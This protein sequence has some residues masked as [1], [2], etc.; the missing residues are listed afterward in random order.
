MHSVY[1][2]FYNQ[3]TYF[4]FHFIAPVT[5][6]DKLVVNYYHAQLLNTISSVYNREKIV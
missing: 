5:K 1:G 3:G 2:S 4:I 6:N